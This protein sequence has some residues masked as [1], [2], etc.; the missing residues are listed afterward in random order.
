MLGL[1][2][3]DE[4]PTIRGYAPPFK[5]SDIDPYTLEDALATLDGDGTPEGHGG[6]RH[7]SFR[8]KNEF[9]A[10]WD[11]YD[12]QRWTNGIIDHPQMYDPADDGVNIYGTSGG[13]EGVVM[14]RTNWGI[15][16]VATGFPCDMVSW[17]RG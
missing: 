3:P 9:P 2:T 8:G 4:F 17:P 15:I 12:V 5:R 7:G 6:H 16:Y 11:E 1:M 14:V 10:G 13:V